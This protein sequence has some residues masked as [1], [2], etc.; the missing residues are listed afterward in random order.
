VEDGRSF[1][2][3]FCQFHRYFFSEVVETLALCH[4]EY[5]NAYELCDAV[6]GEHDEYFLNRTAHGMMP[7]DSTPPPDM[8]INFI[9]ER[10]YSFYTMLL[11]PVFSRHMSGMLPNPNLTVPGLTDED[12]VQY[13][14]QLVT[15]NK[16]ASVTNVRYIA[17]LLEKATTG[18]IDTYVECVGSRAVFWLWQRMLET[19]PVNVERLMANF[20]DSLTL[21][22]YKNI[23]MSMSPEQ[24]KPVIP[25][26]VAE[27]MYTMCY[28]LDATEDPKNEKELQEIKLAPQCSPP[29]AVTRLNQCGAFRFED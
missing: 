16:L 27:M 17:H 18:D 22:E 19:A 1:S 7:G 10:V 14:R 28:T 13:H 5:A 12:Y 11:K 26:I 6:F 24:D 9:C 25:G 15:S 29:H 21:I 4:P 23:Q 8:M 2:L 3:D 20:M